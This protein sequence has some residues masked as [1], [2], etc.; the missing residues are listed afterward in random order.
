P[1]GNEVGP[2]LPIE[3]AALSQAVPDGRRTAVFAWYNLVGSFA[4]AFGALMAGTFVAGLRHAGVA[5]LVAYQCV[6][7]A[8]AVAGITLAILFAFLSPAADAAPS[9]SPL[10]AISF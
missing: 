4:T 5:S 7:F 1:P 9:T 3:Q 8:Y 10:R 6:M 2:F